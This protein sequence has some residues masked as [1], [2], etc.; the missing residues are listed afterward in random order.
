MSAIASADVL[1]QVSYF[2][3]AVLFIMGAEAHELARHRTQRHPVGG[4][5]DA[6]SQP[7]SHS[8]YRGFELRAHHPGHRRRHFTRHGGS[9][10][11]VGHDRYPAMMRAS[12]TA[13]A[14]C[15]GGD[16]RGGA[17]SGGTAGVAITT[18]AVV[19]RH[20]WRRS[21]SGGQRLAFGKLQGPHPWQAC[22]FGGKVPD[23]HRLGRCARARRSGRS[24][25]QHITRRGSPA[26]LY[27]RSCSASA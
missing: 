15:G 5:W 27:W 23:A 3:T 19:G 25:A 4:R 18:L 6:W 24:A 12:I 2:V 8:S 20:Y 16:R 7:S 13:W 14:A 22:A 1:I 11:R 21:P 26:S 10:K 17:V 9:G